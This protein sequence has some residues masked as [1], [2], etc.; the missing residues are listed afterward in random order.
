MKKQLLI[1]FIFLM[2]L[3]TTRAQETITLSGGAVY[4]RAIDYTA[5]YA[6][7]YNTEGTGFRITG[8]YEVG[9][10]VP[11]KLLHGF[12]MGYI[13]TN[14][15]IR[16]PNLT[17][18]VKVRTLPMYYAP[19]YMIGS[20]KAS[21]FVRGAIGMQFAR[22]KATGQF[23]GSDHDWGFYGGVALGGMIH[24]NKKMFLNLEYEWAYMSNTYY[25]NGI[26][27]TVQAGF[28]IDL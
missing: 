1:F 17:A 8:T 26:L 2:A 11:K 12:S 14:T 27:N 21:V 9:P 20:E 18:D 7:D 28:G 22:F 15:E 13:L 6:Y 4:S 16:E 19:K 5:Y 3:T 23:E 24:L 25:V 10:L